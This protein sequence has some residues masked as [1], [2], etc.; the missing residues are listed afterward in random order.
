MT[1]ALIGLIGIQVYWIN[2]AVKL[3]QQKFQSTVNEALGNVVYQYEKLKTAESLAMK[4][5]LH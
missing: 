1:V 2:S 4:M 5:D 3:R